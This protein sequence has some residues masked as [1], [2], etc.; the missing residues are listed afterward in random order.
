M[1]SA[2]EPSRSDYLRDSALKH[3]Q[4]V[5]GL[6]DERMAEVDERFDELADARNDATQAQHPRYPIRRRR[7]A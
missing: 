7:N 5:A 2:A 1:G 6:T 3:A 4:E